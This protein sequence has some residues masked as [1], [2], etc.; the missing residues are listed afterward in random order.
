VHSS[1]RTNRSIPFLLSLVRRAWDKALR[2]MVEV[3]RV[4]VSTRKE[5]AVG[6]RLVA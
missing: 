6:W 1:H 5:Q 4:G 2:K 3:V